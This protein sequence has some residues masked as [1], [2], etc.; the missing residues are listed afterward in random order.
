MPKNRN[1]DKFV[2]DHL[3]LL[4][5]SWAVFAHTGEYLV[6]GCFAL[7]TGTLGGHGQWV[8]QRLGMRFADVYQE[9]VDAAANQSTG[10]VNAGNQLRYYLEN[11]K[12]GF[13]KSLPIRIFTI[14][15]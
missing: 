9:I 5:E 11:K 15:M 1:S 4:N 2:A 6:C 14:I 13:Q 3:S 7:M 8:N 12:V 10:S